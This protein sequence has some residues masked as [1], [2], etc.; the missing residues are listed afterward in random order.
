MNEQEIAEQEVDFDSPNIHC[1]QLAVSRLTVAYPP[2]HL[3][4]SQDTDDTDSAFKH[5]TRRTMLDPTTLVILNR[6]HREFRPFHTENL[7]ERFESMGYS[8]EFGLISWTYNKRMGLKVCINGQH[9]IA[10]IL[11]QFQLVKETGAAESSIANLKMIETL[12]YYDEGGADIPIS[13][14]LILS[15]NANE[16]SA[17]VAPPSLADRM[18]TLIGFIRINESLPNMSISAIANI[19]HKKRL[20]G[21]L[22]TRSLRRYITVALLLMENDRAAEEFRRFANEDKVPNA[23]SPGGMSLSVL[24]NIV[25]ASLSPPA[26]LLGLIC[27]NVHHDSC[28][29]AG[30]GNQTPSL[31]ESS[32]SGFFKVVKLLSEIIKALS[33]RRKMSEF[34]VMD[35]TVAHTSNSQPQKASYF[36][37]DQI[38]NW[39]RMDEN[40]EQS[41]IQDIQRFVLQRLLSALPPVPTRDITTRELIDLDPTD[42]E[43]TA[44]ANNEEVC[45]PQDEEQD[46]VQ[47]QRDEDVNDNDQLMADAAH[48]GCDGRDLRQAGQENGSDGECSGRVGTG[49]RSAQQEGVAEQCVNLIGDTTNNKY[50]GTAAHVHIVQGK[51]VVVPAKEGGLHRQQTVPSARRLKTP[52]QDQTNQRSSQKKRLRIND[53]G[54]SLNGGTVR[55]LVRTRLQTAPARLLQEVE[56]TGASSSPTFLASRTNPTPQT[57]ETI[58]VAVKKKAKSKGK[59]TKKILQADLKRRAQEEFDDDVAELPAN[60]SQKEGIL[61]QLSAI[62]QNTIMYDNRP[63]YFALPQDHPAVSILGVEGY[64]KVMHH[65]A[66]QNRHESACALF[67]QGLDRS[68]KL[69]HADINNRMRDRLFAL[70]TVHEESLGMLNRVHS[71]QYFDGCAVLDLFSTNF[72]GESFPTAQGTESMLNMKEC[73]VTLFDYYAGDARVPEESGY[74]DKD[75][76]N[77]ITNVGSKEDSNAR[78]AGATRMFS[79]RSAT[80]ENMQKADMDVYHARL[81][82]DMYLAALADILR[83]RT[84]TLADPIHWRHQVDSNFEVDL[85][86]PLHIPSSGGRFILTAKHSLRQ[87]PHCD[88]PQPTPSFKEGTPDSQPSYFMM[89]SGED[90]FPLY[91]WKG[92]HREINHSPESALSLSSMNIPSSVWVPPYSVFIGRGDL[93]HAGAGWSDWVSQEK[94]RRYKFSVRYH[95][96]LKRDNHY[97]GNHVFDRYDNVKYGWKE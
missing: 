8:T 75:F 65:F 63:G 43:N 80:N 7:R 22:K 57:E 36:V 9:R 2:E 97:L 28:K 6:V 21:T 55:S 79:P 67:P 24:S 47:N 89:V 81:F 31:T 37:A 5:N 13:D 52:R 17:C 11:K 40:S 50:G 58:P 30:G 86:S 66:R 12:E 27:V 78:G 95:V 26:I 76:W 38:K 20:L 42:E 92:S 85:Q 70:E 61:E 34:D 96:Y 23:T 71:S 59:K 4:L 51:D 25:F 33:Q 39:R 68:H 32:A 1:E 18:G 54:S 73:I 74:W 56:T 62:G 15:E 87:R 29:A 44:D 91:V 10:A 60:V 53:Q 3:L 90:G 45:S 72:G 94:S 35:F 16:K 19:V 64:L 48:D 83:L 82:L 41:W 46:Q 88:F 14:I 69:F 84:H 77:P 49:N 93:H